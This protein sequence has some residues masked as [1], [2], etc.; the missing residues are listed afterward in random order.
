MPRR[1]P[2][3]FFAPSATI[4]QVLPHRRPHGPRQPVFAA[5]ASRRGHGATIGADVAIAAWPRSGRLAPVAAH[6]APA[7]SD[8]PRRRDAGTW[9]TSPAIAAAP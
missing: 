6:A 4:R 9:A 1:M 5:P 8:W 2:G 3:L 7:W